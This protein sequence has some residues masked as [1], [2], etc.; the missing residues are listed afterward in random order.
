MF[1]GE[2]IFAQSGGRD[3]AETVAG[4]P[5]FVPHAPQ[6]H[7]EGHVAAGLGAVIASGEEQ[8]IGTGKGMELLQG[9][10]GLTRQRNGVRPALLH[11]VGRNVPETSVTVEFFPAGFAQFAGAYSREHQ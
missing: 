11:A 5:A 9:G 1:L 8:G 6:C 4:L 7:V 10:Q 2:A 3:V